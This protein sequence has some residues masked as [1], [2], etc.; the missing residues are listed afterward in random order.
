MGTTHNL[1]EY[2][3]E[4]R[5]DPSKMVNRG[6]DRRVADERR[7]EIRDSVW[8]LRKIRLWIKSIFKP[9]LGVDRRK[10][11]DRRFDFIQKDFQNP[12]SI[13]TDVELRLLLS[14]NA[15]MDKR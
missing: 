9:R 2:K 12:Q 14:D 10:G 7:E 6:P 5:R 15:D 3:K 8:R 13:L 1:S 4:Q 11:N